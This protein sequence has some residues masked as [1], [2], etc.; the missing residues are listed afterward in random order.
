M[1]LIELHWEHRTLFEYL[2]RNVFNRR[3]VTMGGVCLL[4]KIPFSLVFSV[5]RPESIMMSIEIHLTSQP[6]SLDTPI[7]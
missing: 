6:E 7:D 4:S 5:Y 2:V 3:L 1:A